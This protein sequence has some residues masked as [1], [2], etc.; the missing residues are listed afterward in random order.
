MAK[1]TD[2]KVDVAALDEGDKKKPNQLNLPRQTH[3]RKKLLLFFRRHLCPVLEYDGG[4][5]EFELDFIGVSSGEGN[6][7][8]VELVVVF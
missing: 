2:G 4:G 8:L 3:Q 7:F 1:P 6:V 5:A